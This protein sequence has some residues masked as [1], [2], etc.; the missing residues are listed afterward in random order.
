MQQV[1]QSVARDYAASVEHYRQSGV[2]VCVVPEHR[3]H[4][5]GMERIVLEQRVVRL[6]EYV[7]AVLVLRSLGGVA[8]ELA[9]LELCCPHLAVAETPHL[10]VR[11]EEV[12]RLY[13]HTVHAHRLLESL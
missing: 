10:E 8:D 7:R 11:G 1:F 12:H 6:E 2:Q 9:A 5:V 13:T 4:G 3:L